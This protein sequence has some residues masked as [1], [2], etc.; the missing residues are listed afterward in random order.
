MATI[1]MNL[2]GAPRTIANLRLFKGS[3]V[4]RVFRNSMRK[5]LT[6]MLQAVRREYKASVKRRRGVK[7]I[8]IGSKVFARPN[9]MTGMVGQKITPDRPTNLLQWLDSGTTARF[10]KG[11]ASTGKM[12]P[13]NFMKRAVQTS[14]SRTESI[15][16]TE[17]DNQAEKEFKKLFGS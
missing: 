8:P 4:R 2:D 9:G 16:Q 6:P 11:G 12:N 15:F 10:R 7:A 5:A 17:L 14:R 3:V 1:V 13:L